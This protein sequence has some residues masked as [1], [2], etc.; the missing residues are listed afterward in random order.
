MLLTISYTGKDTQNI[1]FLF[2]KNPARPQVF[3][4]SYGKAFVFYPEVSSRK[5]TIAL[6][7]DIDP[8]DLARGKEGSAGGGLFDYVNDRPYVSSSFMSVAIAR[9]FGSA[10]GGRGE[11]FQTLADAALD[12]TVT[13]AMLPCR[14]E[15]AM[16]HRVFEPLGYEV[17]FEAFASD[18]KF[19]EWRDSHYVNLTLRGQI[20]LAD[21]LHHLYVLIPV[22][23]RNKH[24]WVGKEEVDKL[25]RHSEEWLKDHPEKNFIARRY[26]NKSRALANLALARLQAANDETP[27]E[28]EDSPP[29]ESEEE[30]RLSLNRQ[31]L[32]SVLAAV[33][34]CGAR[35]VIDLG[36]GEGHLRAGRPEAMTSSA[37][38]LLNRSTRAAEALGA[39][40]IGWGECSEPQRETNRMAW[41]EVS[42]AHCL[43]CWGSRCSPQP[44]R[45]IMRIIILLTFAQ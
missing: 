7:L 40:R 35:S 13:L 27:E 22:F 18:E 37:C 29:N 38:A 5:T 8:V 20:R 34:A 21:L 31:R 11:A 36:C 3:E 10:V 24:Y 6:L 15:T 17:S 23:D 33:R 2:H 32:G 44:M 30:K 45:A 12:L 14:S 16:L 39:A 9:V 43:F 26:L 41:I 28:D 19:P 25:L 42:V 4:L 1:G